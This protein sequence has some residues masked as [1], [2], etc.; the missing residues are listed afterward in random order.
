MW[1]RQSSCHG[2]IAAACDGV[3]GRIPLHRQPIFLCLP[4]LN[5]DERSDQVVI[6]GGNTMR[7]VCA[8]AGACLLWSISVPL[9][10][11]AQD[12]AT[13]SRTRARDLGVPFDGTPGPFNAITDVPGV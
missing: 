7:F 10:T 6:L 3:A 9:S 5:Y 13:A 2:G 12:A 8:L 4:G 1:G 11:V